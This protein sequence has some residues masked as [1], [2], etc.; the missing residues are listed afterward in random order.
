MTDV[1]VGGAA[2]RMGSR[3]VACLVEAPEFRL[4]AALEA[5]GHAGGRPRRR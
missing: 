1:V 5:V 3:L 4:A 2:G